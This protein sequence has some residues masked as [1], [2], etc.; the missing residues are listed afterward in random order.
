LWCCPRATFAGVDDRG[1]A[2]GHSS[3]ASKWDSMSAPN[4][5][6]H[7]SK[8]PDYGYLA[9]RIPTQVPPISSRIPVPLTGSH[10]VVLLPPT[11]CRVAGTHIVVQYLMFVQCF[12]LRSSYVQR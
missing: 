1:G 3:T 11:Q 8:Q 9:M 10:N 7:I 4:I 6:A 12:V 2:A 5:A